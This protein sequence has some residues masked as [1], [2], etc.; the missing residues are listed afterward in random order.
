LNRSLTSILN[1]TYKNIEI[2]V[3]DD[4][5]TD[6]IKKIIYKINDNRIRYI[7]LKKNNGPSYARN[8][9]IKKAKGE[10]HL[11]KILMIYILKKN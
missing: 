4:G 3:V 6:N 9:G 1:Q 10:Y 11:F 5:S 8:F 7:K 2:I